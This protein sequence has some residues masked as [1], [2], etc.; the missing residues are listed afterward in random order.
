ML[1]FYAY[2]IV[3]LGQV[4]QFLASSLRSMPWLETHH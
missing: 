4:I 2:L 1:K 3:D